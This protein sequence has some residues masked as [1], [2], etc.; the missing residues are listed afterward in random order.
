MKLSKCIENFLVHCKIEKNLNYKT[1]RAY[2]IDLNG[3]ER[4]IK[5]ENICDIDKNDI[6]SYLNFLYNNSY[7][8]KTIKRKIVSVKALF[9]FAEFEEIILQNPFRKIKITLKEEK[10]LPKV[11]TLSQIE[12][13][14]ECLKKN[15][16]NSKFYKRN[17]LIIELLL[18][19]GIRVFELCQIKKESIDFDER[20]ILIKGKGGKERKIYIL[21]SKT[22]YLLKEVIKLF[23][24]EKGY[25]FL[26]KNNKPITDQMVRIIVKNYCKKCLGIDNITPHIF[27]H[28]FAT[29]LIN[30]GVDVRHI[31]FLL[32]HSS[33]VTTQIYTQINENLCKKIIIK[34]PVNKII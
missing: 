16:K 31:Q 1:I 13:L 28:T 27:R 12:R 25:I 15:K 4:F 10:K 5:K 9:N 11:L 33:I 34:N 18:L 23:K 21:N 32:G 7:K 19:S 8:I 22:F 20:S 30:N 24:I 6:K 14:F 17:L 3:F 29:I 26:N 2:Q